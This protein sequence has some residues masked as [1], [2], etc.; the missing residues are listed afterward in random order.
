MITPEQRVLKM[1]IDYQ[2]EYK[3][4]TQDY[5][6]GN[7]YWADKFMTIIGE[8][9]KV[10]NTAED[11]CKHKNT[12]RTNAHNDKGILQS[13]EICNDCGMVI[14]DTAEDEPKVFASHDQARRK[15]K[16]YWLQQEE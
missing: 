7:R 13:A 6:P 2:Q 3:D 14:L 16:E 4:Q 1:F 5:A 10:L 11:E 8:A 15:N 12:S 9:K